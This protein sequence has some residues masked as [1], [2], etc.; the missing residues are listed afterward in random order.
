MHTQDIANASELRLVSLNWPRLPKLR[1]LA[2]HSSPSTLPGETNV[3]DLLT[4]RAALTQI[5]VETLIGFQANYEITIK[6]TIYFNKIMIP[7]EKY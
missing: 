5:R 1:E 6:I 4:A 3:L 7:Y 2:A